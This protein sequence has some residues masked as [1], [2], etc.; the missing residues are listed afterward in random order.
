[1][2]ILSNA[3]LDLSPCTF[4]SAILSS[5]IASG[6]HLFEAGTLGFQQGFLQNGSEQL[7][8]CQT[9]E[10]RRLRFPRVE[11]FRV[12]TWFEFLHVA[13]LAMLGAVVLYAISSGPARQEKRNGR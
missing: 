9:G 3:S 8:C 1:M 11:G 12:M 2:A 4:C 13:F 7:G 6:T 10:K 5:E